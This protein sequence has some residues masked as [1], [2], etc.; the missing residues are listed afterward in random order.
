[1]LERDIPKQITI[2][3][4][5]GP[6]PSDFAP[7]RASVDGHSTGTS[8]AVIWCPASAMQIPQL[9]NTFYVGMI[10]QNYIEHG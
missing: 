4:H 6:L 3:D 2:S 10:A 1:M 9:S 8:S 7:K 5:E